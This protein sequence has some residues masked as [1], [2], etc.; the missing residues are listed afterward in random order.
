MASFTVVRFFNCIY[1]LGNLHLMW[2][3]ILSNLTTIGTYRLIVWDILEQL[4]P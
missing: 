2:S 4:S 3:L 1:T